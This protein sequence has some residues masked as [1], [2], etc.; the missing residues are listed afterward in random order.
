MQR[1]Q[2]AILKTTILVI[3]LLFCLEG[4]AL[5]WEHRDSSGG[6]HL[7]SKPHKDSGVPKIK[8]TVII[9]RSPDHVGKILTDLKNHHRFVPH[10]KSI[11]VL[12]QTVDAD[13]TV[14]QLL[15]QVNDLPVISNRDVV[16]VSETDRITKNEKIFWQSTFKAVTDRGPKPSEDMVRIERMTG[17]WGVSPGPRRGTSKVTYITH[18]EVGG[19]IPDKLAEHAQISALQ[20]LLKALTKHAIATP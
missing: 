9:P 3:A 20:D 15:H 11:K 8:G 5:G 12:E 4:N 18:V 19:L 1:T 16:L 10:M 6:V 13:G 2:R 14:I 7:Y 17:A